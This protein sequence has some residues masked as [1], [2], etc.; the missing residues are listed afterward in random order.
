VALV[1]ERTIPT[2]K[3]VTFE[4]LTAVVMKSIIFWDITPCNPLKVN[5]S[6]GETYR[7]HLQGLKISRVRNQRKS[8]GQAELCL[9]YST[10]KMEATCSYETS[11]DFQQ[12]TRH[13]I[14]EDIRPQILEKLSMFKGVPFCMRMAVDINSNWDGFFLLRR[15]RD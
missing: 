13:Y 9:A 12:T 15:S 5:R 7:L 8:R 14:P 3:Y 6:F 2:N 1:R 11:V 4:V 10:L